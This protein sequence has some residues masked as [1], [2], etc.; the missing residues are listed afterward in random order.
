M[1]LKKPAVQNGVKLDEPNKC[2]VMVVIALIMN[3]C[4]CWWL[5]KSLIEDFQLQLIPL[6]KVLIVH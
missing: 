3:R 4:R 1:K 2:Y 6:F 5:F